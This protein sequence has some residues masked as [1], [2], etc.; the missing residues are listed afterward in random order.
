MAAAH[1]YTPLSQADFS[2]RINVPH[3]PHRNRQPQQVGRPIESSSDDEDEDEGKYPALA[4]DEEGEPYGL[5]DGVD[6]V[7]SSAEDAVRMLSWR[8]ISGQKC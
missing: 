2:S 8:I 1:I 5:Q 3:Q 4:A 6:A 7:S